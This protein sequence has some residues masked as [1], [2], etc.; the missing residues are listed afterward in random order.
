MTTY[1]PTQLK[2]VLAALELEWDDV[3]ELAKHILRETYR[4]DNQRPKRVLVLANKGQPFATFGPFSST[5]SAAKFAE[6]LEGWSDS[7]KAGVFPLKMG[8]EE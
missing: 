5:G 7:V 1:T 8:E 4:L 6:T 2:T 3:T